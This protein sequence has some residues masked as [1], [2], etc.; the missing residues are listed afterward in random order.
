M[1]VLAF[2]CAPRD[3]LHGRPVR[4]AGRLRPRPPLKRLVRPFPRKMVLDS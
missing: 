4:S 2:G 3:C 1:S